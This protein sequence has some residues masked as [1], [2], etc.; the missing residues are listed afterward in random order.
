MIQI[1][2]VVISENNDSVV[3]LDRFAAENYFLLKI[4]GNASSTVEGIEMIK[5]KKPAV[6]FIDIFYK[7]DSFFEVMNQLDFNAPK[8]ILISQ[9]ENDAVKAFKYNAIDFIFK[10]IEFN[11]VILSLYKVAKRIEMEESNQQE[12]I[13]N[14]AT[15]NAGKDT[16]EYVAIA[17]LDKIELIKMT[18]IIFCKAD[19]RNTISHLINGKKVMSSRNLGEYTD[20]LDKKYFFRIHHSYIINI[21]QICKISKK[22]GFF[23]E[24]PDGI[25]LPVAKRRQE[26]FNVF[27]GLKE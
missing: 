18:Q 3:L 20:I 11:K 22:D 21:S 9:Y 25:I 17:S 10:P 5:Q 6:V 26:D 12:K 4:V 1:N 16:N 24:M 2:A 19:G 23:C 8:L 27:I 7:D 14:I 15:L 13:R